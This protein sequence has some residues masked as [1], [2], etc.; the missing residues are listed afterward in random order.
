MFRS[1]EFLLRFIRL[2][3]HKLGIFGIFWELSLTV[4]GLMSAF[5]NKNSLILFRLGGGGGGGGGKCPR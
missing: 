2:D 1:I 3:D 5:K 4:V